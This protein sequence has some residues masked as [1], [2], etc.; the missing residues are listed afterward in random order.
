MSEKLNIERAAESNELNSLDFE[1]PQVEIGHV[2]T[3]SESKVEER[4][5]ATRQAAIE[6]AHEA[7]SSATAE[8]GE[9]AEEE[10]FLTH[11][12]A[13]FAEIT[14]TELESF[15]LRNDNKNLSPQQLDTILKEAKAT[16]NTDKNPA[17][18]AGQVFRALPIIYPF[19]K[20]AA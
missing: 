7:I 14:P 18:T 8:Q 13:V 9:S 5:E 15:T 3:L 20:K 6:A 16:N 4:I 2:D 11:P 19:V 17:Q 1:I 10:V 12:D